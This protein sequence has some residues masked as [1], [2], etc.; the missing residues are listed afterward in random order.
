M[1]HPG[2]GGGSMEQNPGTRSHIVH[3][4]RHGTAFVSGLTGAVRLLQHLDT[5][6]GQIPGGHVGSRA[7]E[8]VKAAGNTPTVDPVP[9]TNTRAC[10]GPHPWRRPPGW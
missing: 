5:R 2:L 9:S 1:G 7:K 4:L 3:D 8:A 6:R 10:R